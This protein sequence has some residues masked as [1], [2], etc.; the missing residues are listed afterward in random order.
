MMDQQRKSPGGAPTPQGAKAFSSEQA[1]LPFAPPSAA[2]KEKAPAMRVHV[3]PPEGPVIAVPAGRLAQTLRHLLAVGDTGF[4]SGEVSPLGWAR[5][6]SAYIAKLRALG[7]PIETIRETL[8]D[9]A[10][11]GRYRLS[12]PVAALSPRKPWESP[13]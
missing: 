11:I 5:R 4:T 13:E 6:T 3:R 1:P 7:V 10:C 8:P 12:G 9:G 2:R